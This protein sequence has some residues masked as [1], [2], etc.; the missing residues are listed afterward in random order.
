[1][2]TAVL[3]DHV[4]TMLPASSDIASMKR[5]PVDAQ[6]LLDDS[7]SSERESDQLD[8][9]VEDLNHHIANLQDELEDILCGLQ[10]QAKDK[11]RRRLQRDLVKLEDEDLPE[12][13]RELKDRKARREIEES[14]WARDRDRRNE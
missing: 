1:M 12:L 6:K 4:Q 10:T 13:V 11:R 5:K 14:V 3:S 2:S 9:E 7:L 8:Q